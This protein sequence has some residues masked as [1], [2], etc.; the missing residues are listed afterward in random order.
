MKVT[1]ASVLYLNSNVFGPMATSGVFLVTY[2]VFLKT[3][4]GHI[5]G[6]EDFPQVG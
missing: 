6:Q 2:R 5:W 3:V 4:Q 1:P